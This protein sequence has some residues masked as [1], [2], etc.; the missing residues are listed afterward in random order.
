ME[1]SQPGLTKADIEELIER[2]LEQKLA[3]KALNEKI[4]P[5]QDLPPG[6]A[7]AAERPSKSASRKR[8]TQRAFSTS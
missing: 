8:R 3:E 4:A 7:E 5:V 1:K 2:R 6:P